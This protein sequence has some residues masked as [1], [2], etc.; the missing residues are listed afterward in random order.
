M[1][2]RLQGEWFRAYDGATQMA[3][4]VEGGG[5]REFVAP[6]PGQDVVLCLRK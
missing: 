2:Y 1:R 5:E 6:W 3:D 4:A